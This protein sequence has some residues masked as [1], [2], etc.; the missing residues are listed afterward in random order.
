MCA[1]SLIISPYRDADVPIFHS[2]EDSL[3][4]MMDDG[5]FDHNRVFLLHPP[6]KACE[7]YP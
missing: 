4:G 5:V 7:A 2:K 3:I 1:H 6:D